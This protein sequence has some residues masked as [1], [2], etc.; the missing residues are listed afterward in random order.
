MA[1]LP[2]SSPHVGR[3]SRA[4]E[5]GRGLAA[6]RLARTLG[7]ELLL[8]GLVQYESWASRV[9]LGRWSVAAA[10]VIAL[11]ALATAWFAPGP[12]W[13]NDLSKLTPVPPDARAKD[14][15]LRRELGAPDVRY[16]L[17]V[18]GD[19]AEAALRRVEALHADLDGLVARRELAGWDA[20]TRALPSAATQRAPPRKY[21]LNRER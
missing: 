16:V 2:S 13:P 7:L 1:S 20:A 3:E 4:V 15:H 8:A 5:A 10:G 19:D 21:S 6:V 17:A 12:F 9:V 11:V 14:A 18:R